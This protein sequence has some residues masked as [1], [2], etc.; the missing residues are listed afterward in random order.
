MSYVPV[1]PAVYWFVF[2]Q[3]AEGKKIYEEMR[4]LFWDVTVTP[5]DLDA[6]KLAFHAGERYVMLEIISKVEAG[7]GLNNNNTENENE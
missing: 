5:S 4:E 6:M 2:T 3:T 1:D 7:S